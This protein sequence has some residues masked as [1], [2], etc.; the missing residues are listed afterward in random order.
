MEVYVSLSVAYSVVLLKNVRI[1]YT[2]NK[3]IKKFIFRLFG[4]SYIYLYLAFS[5]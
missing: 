4:N 2:E 3:N 1:V 5:Q